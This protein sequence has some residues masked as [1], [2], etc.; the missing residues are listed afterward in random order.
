MTGCAKT[1]VILAAG[2]GTR[3]GETGKLMPKGFLQLGGRPIVEESI[4]RLEAAGIERVVIVTGYMRNRYEALADSY[5]GFVHTVHN[6]VFAKSGSLYSLACARADLTEDFLLLESDLIYEQ[7][8]LETLQ[9]NGRGGLLISGPTGAG[10]EVWVA[11]NGDLLCD[12][13]K[14]KSHLD[15]QVAGELVGITRVSMNFF[16]ALMNYSLPR[17]HKNPMLEYEVDGLVPAARKHPLR[18]VLVSDL[19]WAEIDDDRQLAA[20]QA[21]VYPAIREKDGAPGNTN[22]GR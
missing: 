5:P 15:G 18:C 17:L 1:A 8:A 20:A 12:M 11:S 7:R 9:A 19:L 3:L 4:M 6:P 10:D 2:M 16:S 21:H 14:D 13:S 22:S